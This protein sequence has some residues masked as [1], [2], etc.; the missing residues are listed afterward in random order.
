MLGKGR[1]VEL[2]AD[3]AALGRWGELIVP[4][5]VS[6][7]IETANGTTLDLDERVAE[8]IRRS[9]R[10]LD[11]A[12]G[13]FL[14]IPH[15][16]D[17]IVAFDLAAEETWEVARLERFEERGFRWIEVRP[18]PAGG[19]LVLYEYGLLCVG[20]DGHMLWYVIHDDL[21]AGFD[22][23]D[24]DYVTIRSQF[25]DTADRVSKY[26]LADGRLLVS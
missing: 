18:T 17:W 9:V 23:V 14:V 12:S 19:L 2:T 20:A 1:A 7:R 25:P 15:Q 3:R 6:A 16:D 21:T 11:D 8:R 5:I 22:S 4:D 10:W 24:R 13:L 26:S